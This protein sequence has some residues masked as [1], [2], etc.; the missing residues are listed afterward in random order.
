[1]SGKVG[2]A[3][4]SRGPLTR[5]EAAGDSRLGVRLM[6][7]MREQQKMSYQAIADHFGVPYRR[8]YKALNRDTVRRWDSES[9]RRHRAYRT[10][11]TIARR[12]ERAMPCERCGQPLSGPTHRSPCRQ[13]RLE[14]YAEKLETLERL[15]QQNLPVREIAEMLGVSSATVGNMATNAR[16][17]GYDLPRRKGGAIPWA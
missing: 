10:A 12:Q 8:V 9:D 15:W 17:R 13:C 6:R 11:Q 14:I 5:G 4:T 2:V 1:M 16:K 7:Q 3:D